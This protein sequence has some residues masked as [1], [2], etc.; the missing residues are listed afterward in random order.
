MEN[1]TQ[2]KQFLKMPDINGNGCMVEN[3]QN[4]IANQE[5]RQEG[6]AEIKPEVDLSLIH[7]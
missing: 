4:N 7:I 6:A 1:I 3:G 5:E 2:I